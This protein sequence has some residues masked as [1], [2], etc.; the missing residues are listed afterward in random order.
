MNTSLTRR[1]LTFT[2][3]L[4]CFCAAQAEAIQ[5]KA[6]PGSKVIIE[7]TSTMHDWRVEGSLIGGA[8]KLGE[9]FP[10]KPGQSVQP[11]KME[12][13]V[14]AV[15]P[16]TSLRSMKDGKPYSTKMDEIMQEKL[17]KPDHKVVAYTLDELTLVKS[18]GDATSPYEFESKGRLVVAGATNAVTL[19]VEVTPLEDGRVKF[20]TSTKLKMSDY[21]IEPPALT[22]FGVGIKTGDEVDVRIE[23]MTAPAE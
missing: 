13:T 4:A 15:I 6:K 22:V 16:I 3:A 8:A 18:A 17:G 10:L 11:G 14:E 20:T 19:P 7:G 1:T 12:A 21:K 2:L 9:G 5:L 23:W